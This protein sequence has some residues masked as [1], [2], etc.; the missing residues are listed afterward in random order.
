LPEPRGVPEFRGEVAPF[1]DLFFIEAD[2]LTARRDAHQAKAQPVGA[3]FLDQLQRVR[4]VAEQLRHFA[5]LLVT[6]QAREINLPKWNVVFVAIR[7]SRPKL[8]AGN[9]HSRHPEEN[10]VRRG[11]Q[12]ARRIKF[13]TGLFVHCLISPEP[14]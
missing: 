14:G 8:E 6:N 12:H 4:R 10:D 13:L 11:H 3:V 1:F 7:F 5:A 2:I 9:N